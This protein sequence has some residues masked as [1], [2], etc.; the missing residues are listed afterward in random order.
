MYLLADYFT[1]KKWISH[2]AVE[3]SREH[4]VENSIAI[5]LK[6]NELLKKE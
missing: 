5:S 3:I 2:K 6:L 4:N 1:V